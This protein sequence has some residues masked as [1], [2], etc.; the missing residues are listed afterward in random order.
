MGLTINLPYNLEVKFRRLASEKF[1][2]KLGKISSC[3]TEA[4]EEWC[5]KQEKI[6]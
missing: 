5:K 2:D 4:I 1:S 6:K 3:A